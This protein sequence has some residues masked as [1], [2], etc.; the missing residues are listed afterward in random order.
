M[1]FKRNHILEGFLVGILVFIFSIIIFV[2]EKKHPNMYKLTNGKKIYA[3]CIFGYKFLV[4][5]NEIVQI[6][7]EER[8]AIRCESKNNN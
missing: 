3:E 4:T 8:K 6:F 2:P 1:D 7:D 5:N